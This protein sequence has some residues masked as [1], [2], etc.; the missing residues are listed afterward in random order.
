MLAV[1]LMAV[2]HFALAFSTLP[3]LFPLIVDPALYG[4]IYQVVVGT[5]YGG[6]FATLPAI[7]SELFGLKNFG[8][9]W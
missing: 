1:G 6:L 5:A 9:N 2:A 7:T 3:S 4:L 8:A